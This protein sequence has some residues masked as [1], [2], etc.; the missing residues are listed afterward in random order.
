MTNIM[1][2]NRLNIDC[3]WWKFMQTV[4]TVPLEPEIQVHVTDFL[5]KIQIKTL[6]TCFD[7]ELLQLSS[8]VKIFFFASFTKSNLFFSA[9][10]KT[11]S[12]P[13]ARI[14]NFLISI[15]ERCVSCVL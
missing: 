3:R 2:I 8:L 6:N 11:F 9:H 10:R 5:I 1:I 14:S 4:V 15:F 12:L 7:V 13:F